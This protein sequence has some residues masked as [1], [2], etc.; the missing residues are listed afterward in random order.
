MSKFSHTPDNVETV[1]VQSII[2]LVI[3]CAMIFG[4]RIENRCG[5]TSDIIQV[6]CARSIILGD[7][8]IRRRKVSRYAEANASYYFFLFYSLSIAVRGLTA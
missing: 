3:D 2:T 5:V 7:C 1:S 8:I 4:V 6:G